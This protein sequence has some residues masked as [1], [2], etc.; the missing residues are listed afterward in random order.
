ME[1]I[2]DKIFLR[3]TVQMWQIKLTQEPA[4]RWKQA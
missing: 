4:Q 2:Q 1:K 3:T